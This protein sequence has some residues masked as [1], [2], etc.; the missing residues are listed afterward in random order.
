MVRNLH[1][2]RF[3]RRT[4]MSSTMT[5]TAE[6]QSVTVLVVLLGYAIGMAMQRATAH[7]F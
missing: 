4:C 7:I 5:R 6:Q 1:G 3:Y 2:W